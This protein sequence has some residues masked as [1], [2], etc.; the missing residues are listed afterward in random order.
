VPDPLDREAFL[1]EVQARL[2]LPDLVAN[3]VIEEVAS[4]IDDGAAELRE[5]GDAP[6]DAERRAVHRLGDPHELGASLSRAHRGRRWVLAAVGGGFRG[7]I[8]EGSRLSLFLLAAGILAS[9]VVVVAFILLSGPGELPGGLDVSSMSYYYASRIAPWGSL[10]PVALVIAVSAYLGWAVPAR[11]AR[12]AVRSVAGVRRQVAVV[13]VV[14]GSVLVWLVL[15]LS[16]DPILAIGYPLAPIAFGIAALR[17]PA[18]PRFRP[19]VRGFLALAAVLV[20]LT[21]AQI[22]VLFTAPGGRSLTADFSTVGEPPD[23]VGLA[24]DSVDVHTWPIDSG[25]KATSIGRLTTF[26]VL[27]EAPDDVRA[28]FPRLQIEVW[29]V[30]EEDGVLRAGAA[31]LVVLTEPTQPN[32]RI[33]WSMPHPRASVVVATF[34]LGVTPEGRRVVLPDEFGE[35]DI[36]PTPPW[37]GTIANYW[38]GS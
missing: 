19:G 4:H 34:V 23:A 24:S 37:P 3:E 28:L 26:D 15:P 8:V 20:A 30:A 1:T 11:V 14:L 38:F 33:E 17:A 27:S 18:Q 10:G 25:S 13:G 2:D 36:G 7:V 29:P 9:V 5:Q 6:D 31:P 12:S 22:L 16:L 35:L 21:A 32:S